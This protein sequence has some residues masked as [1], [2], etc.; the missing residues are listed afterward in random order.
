MGRG[1]ATDL[2]GKTVEKVVADSGDADFS[3]WFCIATEPYACPCGQATVSFCTVAHIILVWPTM[4]DPRMIEMARFLK[5]EDKRNPRIVEYENE[6]GKCI[7][8]YKFKA[9]RK[10]E[11][12]Q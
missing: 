12:H 11:P 9:T 7:S 8:Y 2:G 6:F 5:S 1:A 3:G 10:P 4:D